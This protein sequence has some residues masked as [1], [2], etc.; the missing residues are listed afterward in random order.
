MI[1]AQQYGP[2]EIVIKLR[3]DEGGSLVLMFGAVNSHGIVNLVVDT[4]QANHII[5][6]V[7]KALCIGCMCGDRDD[8]FVLKNARVALVDIVR[9]TVRETEKSE[10]FVCEQYECFRF[11]AR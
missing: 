9:N 8:N 10:C 3:R 4:A 2:Q 6:I 5:S 1:P 11:M 7:Q